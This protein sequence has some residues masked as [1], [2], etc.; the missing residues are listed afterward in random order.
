MEFVS[1][2]YD[3]TK[4]D[5][6]WKIDEAESDRTGRTVKKLF[7]EMSDYVESNEWTVLHE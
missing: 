7:F 6:D 4:M 3:L 5:I 1:W 2:N